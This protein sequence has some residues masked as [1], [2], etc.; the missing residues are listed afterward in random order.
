MS[1]KIM[2]NPAS[3]DDKAALFDP[4]TGEVAMT[5]PKGTIFKVV[6][7]NNRYYSV[8]YDDGSVTGARG[9]TENTGVIAAYPSTD[10]YQ[11]SD[12]KR[13]IGKMNNGTPINILDDSDPSI[14]KVSGISTN[15]KLEGYVRSKY[16]VRDGTFEESEEEGGEG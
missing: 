4:A 7:S 3:G 6:D 9:G 16:I 12:R 13:I 8:S 2:I 5:V 11:E 15:G 10:L 1:K 14:F